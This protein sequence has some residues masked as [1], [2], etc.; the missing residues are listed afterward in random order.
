MKNQDKIARRNQIIAI[1]MCAVLLL[2]AVS[3]A[4][5]YILH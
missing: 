4:L 5:I 1:A 2:G 3:A